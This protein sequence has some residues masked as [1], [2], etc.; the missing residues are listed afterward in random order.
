MAH[1]GQ[2]EMAHEGQGDSKRDSE[3]SPEVNSGPTWLGTPFRDLPGPSQ[4][5]QGAVSG[6]GPRKTPREPP[7]GL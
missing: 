5:L 3:R 7:R 4:T 6:P 1:E 2:R